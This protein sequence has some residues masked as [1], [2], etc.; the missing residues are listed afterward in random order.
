MDKTKKHE[1]KKKSSNVKEEYILQL[2]DVKKIYD[3]GKVKVEAL[4]QIN[5]NIGKNEFIVIIGPSGSGKSTLVNLVGCLDRPTEGKILLKGKDINKLTD[6]QLAQLR[7]KTI[8]FV[9]QQFHLLNTFTALENVT[10]PMI[11][12]DVNEKE[13]IKKAKSILERLGLGERL[14]HKPNELS[15]GQQ[16]RVAIARA[17]ANDP[18]IILA[19]EPTGNL[20]S[21]SGDEVIKILKELHKEGRTIIFVTHDPRYMNIGTRIVKIM[22]GMIVEDSK[23][24]E[25]HA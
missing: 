25:N 6:S 5:L 10:L 3:L 7:G 15:G 4:K 17:L 13:R 20:D 9:F 2:I 8:G 1:I 16:Q 22:D 24:G 19:D 23:N 11:F 12:H 21:K 14:N 18:E